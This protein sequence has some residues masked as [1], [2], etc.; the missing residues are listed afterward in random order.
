MDALLAAVQQR[1]ARRQELDV[2]LETLQMK[3]AAFDQAKLR[4][5]IE[6]RLKEWRG[7]LRKNPAQGQMIL[8]K[9]IVGRIRF[10]PKADRRG[11]YYAFRATG[12][13][14]KLLSGL[15]YNMASLMPPSWNQAASWLQQIDGLRRAAWTLAPHC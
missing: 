9:L 11:R 15:V 12:T 4:Q 13:V 8:R 6:S 1:E 14:E 2:E 10:E 5:K 7:L 3:R